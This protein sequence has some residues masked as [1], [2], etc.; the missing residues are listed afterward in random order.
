MQTKNVFVEKSL[1]FS[2]EIIQFCELLETR[3]NL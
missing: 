1:D 2:V 3:K